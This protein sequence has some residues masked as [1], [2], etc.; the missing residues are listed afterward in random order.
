MYEV[1]MGLL[2]YLLLFFFSYIK[3]DY[4]EFGCILLVIS[5]KKI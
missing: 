5:L 1:V 2:D 3:S 4:R